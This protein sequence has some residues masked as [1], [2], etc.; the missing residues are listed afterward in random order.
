MNKGIKSKIPKVEKAE[1]TNDNE[2]A[3]VGSVIINTMIT[4]PKAD[5]ACGLLETLKERILIMLI[6]AARIQE[7]G[8]PTIH[9]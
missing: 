9:T 2:N 4:K 8:N 5:C 7:I 3:V 1:S 6:Q